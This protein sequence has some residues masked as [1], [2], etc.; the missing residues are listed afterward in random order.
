[1]EELFKN[2]NWEEWVVMAHYDV[3]PVLRSKGYMSK[4]TLKIGF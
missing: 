1:V 4:S 3:P 2:K